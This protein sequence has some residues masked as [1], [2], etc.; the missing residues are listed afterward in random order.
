MAL[1]SIHKVASY[2]AI[3]TVAVGAGLYTFIKSKSDDPARDIKLIMTLLKYKRALVKRQ[4]K[5]WTAADYFSEAVVANPFNEALRFIEDDGSFISYTYAEV[6]FISNRVANWALSVGLKPGDTV[7]LM[8]D[9]RPE[10][11]FIWVGL[12]KIGVI[13]A[14]INTYLKGPSLLHSLSVS[15]ATRYIIGCEHVNAVQELIASNSISGNFEAS[16]NSTQ[17]TQLPP[18]WH[19]FDAALKQFPGTPIQANIRQNL[20]SSDSLFYIYTSGTTGNPKASIIRHLRFYAAG[21]GF[22][23]LFNVTPADRIYCA[24]PLYHSAGGMIGVSLA[25]TKGATLVFRKK[26]SASS[27]WA[28]CARHDISIIQYIGELCRYLVLSPPSPYDNQHRVRLALGNGLRAD[29]WPKFVERFS[30][31]LLKQENGPN[32]LKEI[33]IGEFYAATEGNASLVN[34][35]S[36]VGAIGFI[37][38]LIKPSYPLKIVKFDIENEV[39]IRDEKGFCIECAADEVGELLGKIDDSDPTRQFDGYTDKSA[40]NKK[41]MSDAFVKGDRYF[42]SGDLVRCDKQGFYFFVDRIGDTFRWKGENVSTNEVAEVISKIPGVKE[43]NVYGVSVQGQDGR[44]GMACIVVAHDFDIDLFYTKIK[45]LPSYAAPLF[46]RL[47]QEIDITGTFKHKKTE[48][49]KE[50]FNPALVQDPLYYRND[51]LKKYVP[52]D[53]ALYESINNNK[54][55]SKL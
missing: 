3:G 30:S 53:D 12:A 17:L 51:A 26:F 31:A 20:T 5:K 9:N 55:S 22:Q 36:K 33:T 38:P 40:T 1:P 34:P 18:N 45:E 37:S 15:K 11:V 24:L 32:K 28:D 41:I 10:F 25:W 43:V 6:D 19:N 29:V 13:I 21:V 42:R 52:I 2:G 48:L 39:P 35:T 49:V 8:M 27:F 47:R 44:A 14:L 50:G 46:I 4:N 7:S 16:G 54:L 23:H